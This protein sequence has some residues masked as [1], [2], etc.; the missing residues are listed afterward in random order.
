MTQQEEISTWLASVS[1]PT[2]P[3]LTQNLETDVAIIGGGLAGLLSAYELAKAGKKVVI[4]EKDRVAHAGTGYTTGF[5]AQYID[6][7]TGDQVDMYGAADTK[8]IW[9]SH[10]DAIDL[11]EKIAKDEKIDCEL[12]RCTNYMHANDAREKKELDEEFS[13]MDEQGFSVSQKAI[14]LHFKNKG[15]LSMAKQGKYHPLKFVEGLLT[16]LEKLGVEIYETTEVTDLVP[17]AEGRPFEVKTDNYTVT[18]PW[19]ITATYQ[20]FNN[21]KEVLLKKGMYKSYV[22]ELEVPAGTYEEGTYEDMDNPYH[23]FRVDAGVGNKGSDRIIIG[24]EDHRIE[25]P[26][27]DKN[28]EVLKEYADDLFG[29]SYPVVR[30][31]SGHILESVDGLPF[32]GEYQPHQLIATAFGGNG[33]TYSAISAKLFTDIVMGEKNP[34]E[35]LYSPDRTPTF[36]QLSKKGRD[37]GEE[38]FRG[39]VANLFK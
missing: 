26:M 31:W 34:Y 17:V 11:I 20:P 12:M 16:A 18:A 5:L 32:I 37:F 24:G 21:P 30:Q 29:T 4:L 38:F 28:F 23:Y 7:N 1:L 3:T 36:K 22:M 6:T 15:V 8:K 14:D 39:A 9:E 35:K 13:A 33:M 27:N 25:I 19:T 10:G 2:F